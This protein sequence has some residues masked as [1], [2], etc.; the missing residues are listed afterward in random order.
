[1]KTVADRKEEIAI[2]EPDGAEALSNDIDSKYNGMDNKHENQITAFKYPF[3][4]SKTYLLNND[5]SETQKYDAD[6]LQSIRQIQLLGSVSS[7]F[8]HFYSNY[9]PFEDNLAIIKPLYKTFDEN[10]GKFELKNTEF[11]C[12]NHQL[13][14]NSN[15]FFENQNLNEITSKID[16]LNLNEDAF[17]E[18][19]IKIS[20][21]FNKNL[22]RLIKTLKRNNASKF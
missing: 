13:T 9:E 10:Y 6:V 21:K 5:N 12:Q 18:E 14:I 19:R 15:N 17:D 11:D 7:S 3:I 1:M 2:I 8:S 20:N 16:H 4:H 22:F